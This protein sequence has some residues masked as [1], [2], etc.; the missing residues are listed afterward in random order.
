MR[1]RDLSYKS[2]FIIAVLLAVSGCVQMSPRY[3]KGTEYERALFLYEN[4]R[5]DEALKKADSIPKESADYKYARR[6]ITDINSAY[7]MMS[8]RHADLADDLEKAGIYGQAIEEYRLTL[9]YNPSN[10][11]AKSKIESLTEALSENRS[12]DNKSVA[13]D[14]KRKDERDE[15]EYQANLHYMKGK[16]YYESKEWGRAVEEL[17]AVLKL[18]PA[19]MN[20][21]DL[22]VKARKER[23]AAVDRLIKSGISFFQA[24][25]M[26]LAIK[27]W[28]TALDLEPGN[29][30]AADYRS[31]AE[32]IM[33]RLK[34]IR[35]KQEKRPL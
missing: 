5:L 8:R 9:R 12:A 28:D 6:L 2:F 26:E 34:N 11:L 27:E 17:S 32:V 29:K 13:R 35:E 24:E 3:V 21:K 1:G 10:A 23:D 14:R 25:E 31:R 19:Y 22:L 20:T 15:P 30:T 4:G 7:T 33:E 16:M 18:V